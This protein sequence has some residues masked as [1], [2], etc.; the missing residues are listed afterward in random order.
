MKLIYIL[1]FSMVAANAKIVAV[2][3]ITPKTDDIE[4]SV[5][6]FRHLTDELRTR[7]REALPKDFTI[8]TRDNI[9]QLLPPDEAE[10]ECLAEG[11]AVD[12]GRAIGAEYVTQGFVGKFGKKQ[13]LTVE[14][15]ESMSGNLL[16][17]FVTES[18]EIEGLLTA[19]RKRAP[20]LFAKVPQ[21]PSSK[22]KAE[23]SQV[24]KPNSQI[25]GSKSEKTIN[26]LAVGLDVIGVAAIGFGVLQDS[27]G[28]RLHKDYMA[29][30]ENDA[31][32]KGAGEKV[33]SA[34]TKRNIAYAVGCAFLA[35]GIGVHIWF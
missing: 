2:L 10:R 12:V 6:E 25:S 7:A 4:M 22:F 5:S 29:L 16:G 19:I 11:C 17:S 21:T 32:Y 8:L 34:K 9:L 24:E 27:E 20:G 15:Y 30:T 35:A 28:V 14:L 18:E 1:L 13:T 23:K 31:D 33:E 3:E 26:W